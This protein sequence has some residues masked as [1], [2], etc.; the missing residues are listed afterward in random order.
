MTREESVSQA[1][2]VWVLASCCRRS[3]ARQERRALLSGVTRSSPAPP[4]PSPGPTLLLC[5]AAVSARA[6][7]SCMK[8]QPGTH[9]IFP[10]HERSGDQCSRACSAAPRCCGDPAPSYFEPY[11]LELSSQARVSRRPSSRFLSTYGWSESSPG[12][13]HCWTRGR[14]SV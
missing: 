4:P 13:C 8:L 6:A 9:L 5:P 12:H 1:L 7:L 11:P 10:P 3:P 14:L 2:V